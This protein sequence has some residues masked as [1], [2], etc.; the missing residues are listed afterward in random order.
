VLA[1]SPKKKLPE[2]K[3]DRKVIAEIEKI[4]EEPSKLDKEEPKKEVK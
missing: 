4:K 1:E 3:S 2:S